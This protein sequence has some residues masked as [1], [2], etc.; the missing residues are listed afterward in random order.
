M[1]IQHIV[2]YDI[3]PD[4]LIPSTHTITI[5]GRMVETECSVMC[6]ELLCI[7]PK[8]H[9]YNCLRVLPRRLNESQPILSWSLQLN[10]LHAPERSVESLTSTFLNHYVPNFRTT[11]CR[12]T[13]RRQLLQYRYI[14]WNSQ[15]YG[16]W[17]SSNNSDFNWHLLKPPV[18]PCYYTTEL[19]G[20]LY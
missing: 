11:Y 2:G 6:H 8:S 20:K 9:H 5:A 1:T 17:A 18:Y 10:L 12:C 4:R 15:Q 13:I 7:H 14:Q 3:G 16:W 19:C